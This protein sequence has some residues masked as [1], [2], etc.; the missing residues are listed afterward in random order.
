MGFA[1]PASANLLRSLQ[2]DLHARG[3]APGAAR[4]VRGQ[5][6]GL[7]HPQDN[8]PS[9]KTPTHPQCN[10]ENGEKWGETHEFPSSLSAQQSVPGAGASLSSPPREGL[11]WGNA[12]AAICS[13]LLAVL[14]F[15]P[16]SS[17]LFFPPGDPQGWGQ[18]GRRGPSALTG[19]MWGPCCNWSHAGGTGGALKD[20]QRV[21]HFEMRFPLPPPPPPGLNKYPWPGDA[22]PSHRLLFPG[23]CPGLG[24]GPGPPCLPGDTSAD[25]VLRCLGC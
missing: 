13:L 11:S 1:R 19:D 12:P 7:V 24:K 22:S 10:C 23:L 3:S 17:S 16:S 5:A 2:G 8:H 15:F 4:L 6:L 25:R 9:K 18:A 20:S 21:K 14:A